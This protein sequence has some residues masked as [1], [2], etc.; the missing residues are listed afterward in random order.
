MPKWI[1]LAALTAGIFSLASLGANRAQ[2][3]TIG[4][5]A[6]L[7]IAAERADLTQDVA[8]VCQ[9]VWRCGYWGCGWRRACWWSGGYYSGGWGWRRHYWGYRHWGYRHWHRW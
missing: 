1:L 4:A 9:R 8:Y 7:G 2:A 3:M 6:G 5:P